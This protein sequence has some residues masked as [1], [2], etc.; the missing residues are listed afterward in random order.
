MTALLHFVLDRIAER[1]TAARAALE[2]MKTSDYWGGE[3]GI[4]AWQAGVGGGLGGA[5]GELAA[6]H[7]PHQVLVTCEVKRALI[8]A[9]VLH[10]DSVDR[11]ICGQ[12]HSARIAAPVL[13]LL[14]AEDWQHPDYDAADWAYRP[15]PLL[16]GDGGA[17]DWGVLGG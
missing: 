11:E 2:E 17:Q 10:E 1:E 16:P 9:A 3:H 8:R 13:A 12:L 4:T 7:S 15:R 5:A 6:M 14:A